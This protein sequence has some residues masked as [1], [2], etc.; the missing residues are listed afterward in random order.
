MNGGAKPKHVVPETD[1]AQTV[2]L[3]PLSVFESGVITRAA[4]VD[5][6]PPI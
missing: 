2:S 3:S 5:A 4:L 6:P 1:E